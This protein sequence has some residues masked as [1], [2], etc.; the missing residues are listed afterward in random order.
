MKNPFVWMYG[1]ML[2]QHDR[3][4][5]KKIRRQIEI[6]LS[7]E[8]KTPLTSILAYSE[9]LLENLSD[10][11][12]KE[13]ALLINKNSIE[14]LRLIDNIIAISIFPH[15]SS[16][17]HRGCIFY[18]KLPGCSSGRINLSVNL[19]FFRPILSNFSKICFLQ[20]QGRSFPLL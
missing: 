19:P 13:Y 18:K 2:E 15:Y 16:H 6:S 8:L 17:P 7:H 10:G 9:M 5:E 1:R 3:I 11:Q 4:L 20:L 12:N 14:L